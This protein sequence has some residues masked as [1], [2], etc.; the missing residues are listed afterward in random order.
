MLCAA[1]L[2]KVKQIKVC[3]YNATAQLH[4]TST[5][6]TP[7]SCVFIPMKSGGLSLGK[8]GR[9]GKEPAPAPPKPPQRPRTPVT[10]ATRPSDKQSSRP[11][12]LLH[13][14]K[15]SAYAMTQPASW[16][17]LTWPA[18]AGADGWA[19]L[20]TC[21]GPAVAAA[22]LQAGPSQR[23]KVISHQ[24]HACC[25]VACMLC[26]RL[27]TMSPSLCVALPTN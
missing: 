25:Y 16:P 10:P 19:P 15:G 5:S 3:C 23:L 4:I 21:A 22:D 11:Q 12:G 6:H 14:S 26:C 17:L 2:R 9:A 18:V 24:V 1:K 20:L 13:L 8:A 7:A 27:H